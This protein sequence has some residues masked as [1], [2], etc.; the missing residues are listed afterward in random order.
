MRAFPRC[1]MAVM[2]LG[3]LGNAAHCQQLLYGII[4][5]PPTP[6]AC[7]LVTIDPLTGT[8]TLIG[9]A[10][11]NIDARGMAF[12]PNGKLYVFDRIAKAFLE[13]DPSTGLQVGPPKIVA[14]PTSAFNFTFRNAD[15]M[16]F[17]VGWNGLADEL[18]SFDITLAVPIID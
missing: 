12:H 14:L 2:L 15:G 7:Q 1:L 18:Y 3:V 17:L 13:L 4:S 6:T 5:P 8:R 10:P 16:G 11:L 9:P